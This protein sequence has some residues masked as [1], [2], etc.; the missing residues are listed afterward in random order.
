MLVELNEAREL[1]AI[2]RVA[3]L[4]DILRVG[5]KGDQ[6]NYVGGVVVASKQPSI[7]TRIAKEMRESSSPVDVDSCSAQRERRTLSSGRESTLYPKSRQ[8]SSCTWVVACRTRTAK[9]WLVILG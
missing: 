8:I 5:V 2:A 7:S 4:C 3:E 1:S 9:L 6:R